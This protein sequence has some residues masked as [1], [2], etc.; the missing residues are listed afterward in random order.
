MNP[1]RLPV[2]AVPASPASISAVSTRRPRTAVHATGLK[3]LAPVLVLCAV[4]AAPAAAAPIVDFTGGITSG[5]ALRTVGFEFSLTSSLTIGALGIWDEGANGLAA[6]HEVGLWNASQTLLASVTVDN[7]GVPVAS[8][9]TAGQW[10]FKDL[11]SDV[12]LAPGNY[13][14]GAYYETG[15]DLFRLQNPFSAPLT[16]LT[17]AGVSVLG[18]RRSMQQS[19]GLDF[20][21]FDLTTVGAVN[22]VFGPSLLEATAVVP[23]PSSIL[24]LG[25]GLIALLRKRR[26]KGVL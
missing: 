3:G 26:G 5:A 8:A 21:G 7:T 25:G 14:L 24:L 19:Q 13:F 4:L 11:T 18:P 22:G 23:E 9:F 20:P 10:L 2:R 6:S 1:Q 12:T 17:A 16:V 15:A